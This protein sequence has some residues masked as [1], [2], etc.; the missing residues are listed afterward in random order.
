MLDNKTLKSHNCFI[1]Y[2]DYVNVFVIQI[3]LF[4][5]RK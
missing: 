3:R 4:D 2:N 1:C 5:K